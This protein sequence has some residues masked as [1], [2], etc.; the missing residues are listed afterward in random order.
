MNK[1]DMKFFSLRSILRLTLCLVAQTTLAADY[2]AP[3]PS[4]E[5]FQLEKIPLQVHNMKEISKQ[6]VTLAERPQDNS[7]SQLRASAQMLA[8]AMRLDPTNSAVRECNQMFKQG[9]SPTPRTQQQILQAKSKIRFYKN[10]LVNQKAGKQANLLANYLTDATKI[11]HPDTADNSDLGDWKKVV[12]PLSAYNSIKPKPRPHH[13]PDPKPDPKETPTAEPGPKAKFH[14]ETVQ[15]MVPLNT[16]TKQK[17]RDETDN[18]EKHRTVRKQAITPVTFRITPGKNNEPKLSLHYNPRLPDHKKDPK[19]PGLNDEIASTVAA[20]IQSRHPVAPEQKAEIKIHLGSYSSSNQTLLAAPT[21]LM[22]EASLSNTPLR[23]DIHILADINSQGELSQPTNFWNHLRLLRDS[24]SGGRLIVAPR[25]AKLLIQLLVHSEPEFFTRWEVLT[26]ADLDQA[27]AC[28]A[29]KS[30]EPLQQAS[31]L[32][33]TVQEATQK[34]DVTKLAVNRI[35]RKRL[36]EIVELWPDHASSKILLVQGGGHRPMRLSREALAHEIAPTLYKIRKEINSDLAANLP[37][38][39][40]IKNKHSRFREQL[41]PI[42]RLVDRSHGD[43]YEN[44]Q[45]LTTDYRR[46]ASISRRISS[47]STTA[48]SLKKTAAAIVFKMRGECDKLIL[49]V[50]ALVN[51]E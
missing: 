16:E 8:L 47:D 13:K 18:S 35:V 4:T 9:N 51:G 25:S 17:Y 5:L 37:S 20:L 43:L 49:E 6:L 31:D 7:A 10:W 15:I 28:A 19:K 2:V 26:A 33:A 39:N 46:L 22:L 32:F 11:L 1:P 36:S 44:T 41:D 45:K 38:S 40:T 14:L 23:A 48:D 29:K 24:K 27:L 50:E 21:A 3:N 30:P 12:P 42:E 34:N